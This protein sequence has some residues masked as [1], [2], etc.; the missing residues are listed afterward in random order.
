M[1]V[2]G[3]DGIDFIHHQFGDGPVLKAATTC[4]MGNTYGTYDQL[5]ECNLESSSKFIMLDNETELFCHRRFAVPG[6]G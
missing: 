2:R 3:Y 1:R 6:W 4:D 5:N